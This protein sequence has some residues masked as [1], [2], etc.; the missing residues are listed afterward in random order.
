M[1]MF[2]SVSFGMSVLVTLLVVRS[3]GLHEAFSDSELGGPQKFHLRPVPRIGG[4]SIAAGLTVGTIA[5]A[6]GDVPGTASLPLLLI[7]ALPAFGIGLLEDLTKRVRPATRMCYIAMAAG[8]GI[9]LLDAVIR[10]THVPG[11]DHLL[12]FFPLAILLTLIAVA[13]VVNAVNIIDGFNG[14]ASMC[15]MLMLSGLAYVGY[16]VGD[17]FVAA[18][19]LIALGAVLG[20]FALNYPAGLI[21]LGDGGAYLLGFLLAELSVLLVGRN[22]A[23]SPLFPVVL[24]AYPIVE[25]LFSIYRR[26]ILRGVSPSK[27]D[28]IHLHS[29]IYRRVMRWPLGS[30]Q[31][32]C[33]VR[34]SLTSPFLWILCLMTAIPACIHWN[35]T[36]WLLAYLVLFVA[37]YLLLYWRIV[38]FKVPKWL[39]VRR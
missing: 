17:L 23:V 10:R 31:R 9:L 20:F 30:S 13:G 5:L 11:V 39:I 8:L 2:V 29:L 3:A 1:L 26:K 4:V 33:T 14:L 35:S 27:A 34:N 28:G 15:V 24:C 36:P 7:A 32:Q 16:A 22:E 12:E 25:T 18:S 37:G 6:L 21:F 19:A 38:R